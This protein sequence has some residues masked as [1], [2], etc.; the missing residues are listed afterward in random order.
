MYILYRLSVNNFGGMG[1]VKHPSRPSDTIVL[2]KVPRDL[3]TITKLSGYFERFGTIVN[4]QVFSLSL[5]LSLS[6]S[7]THTHTIIHSI[8]SGT[9]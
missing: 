2:R 9:L 7:H 6:L 5:S 1:G 3:N 8:F 4:L